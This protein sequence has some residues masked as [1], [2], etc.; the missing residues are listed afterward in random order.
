[1]SKNHI[2]DKECSC[3]NCT[4]IDMLV[5]DPLLNPWE[6]KFIR[7]LVDYGWTDDYT[8]RQVTK[9][10]QVWRKIHRLRKITCPAS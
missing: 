4:K 9:L 10:N 8:D 6:R 1:M 7:S 2:I 3:K 5:G